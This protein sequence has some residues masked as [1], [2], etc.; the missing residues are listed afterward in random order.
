MAF[1]LKKGA[2]VTYII[3]NLV[4]DQKYS[5]YYAASNADPVNGIST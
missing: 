4:A 3:D 5:A 2:E 1:F